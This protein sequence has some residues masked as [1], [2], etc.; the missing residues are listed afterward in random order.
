MLHAGELVQLGGRVVPV[1]AFLEEVVRRFGKP[2][3]IAADRWRAGELE[4]GASEVRLGLPE[5]T[6]RGQGWRDGAQDVRLFRAAALEGKIAA[7]VSLSMRA[8]LAEARVVADNSANEK[9]A[10]AGEGQKRRRGR[11]DL[12]A[13]TILA[14]AEGVR[15]GAESPRPRFRYRGAA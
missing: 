2:Q 6:W 4:D 8:A 11:D 9:L 12:A 14:V 5:P 15:R 10:K 1:G 3:A 13:A 7:E